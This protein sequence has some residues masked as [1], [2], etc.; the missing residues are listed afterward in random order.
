MAMMKLQKLK[1]EV[2]GNAGGGGSLSLDW[3]D[4]ILGKWGAVLA[5]AAMSAA[6]VLIMVSF[7]ACCIVPMLRRQCLRAMDRHTDSMMGL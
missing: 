3:L 4:Q 6:I 1:V 5:K 7:L 2:R